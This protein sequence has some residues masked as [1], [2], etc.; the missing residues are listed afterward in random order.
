[1]ADGALTVNLQNGLGR[2]IV[3]TLVS[4]LAYISLPITTLGPSLS[5]RVFRIG[6]III[7][8]RFKIWR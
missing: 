5:A 4:F 7:W 3:F 2:M 6:L 8:F 1:M